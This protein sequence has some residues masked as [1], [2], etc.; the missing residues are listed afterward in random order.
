MGC[1][2]E[3]EGDFFFTCADPIS[4]E[5]DLHVHCGRHWEWWLWSC[6]CVEFPLTCTNLAVNWA[7]KV[8]RTVALIT[9]GFFLLLWPSTTFS[10]KIFAASRTSCVWITSSPY[11]SAS[12]NWWISNTPVVLVPEDQISVGVLSTTL[13]YPCIVRASICCNFTGVVVFFLQ[14]AAQNFKL[15]EFAVTRLYCAWSRYTMTRASGRSI[16]NYS[17]NCLQWGEETNQWSQCLSQLVRLHVARVSIYGPTHIMHCRTLLRSSTAWI[18]LANF[19]LKPNTMA[20]SG[21]FITSHLFLLMLQTNTT[22]AS[23]KLTYISIGSRWLL[24]YYNVAI[25]YYRSVTGFPS[26]SGQLAGNHYQQ[27]YY[28]LCTLNFT[29]MSSYSHYYTARVLNN[30]WNHAS[31]ALTNFPHYSG[32]PAKLGCQIL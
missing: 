13:W 10:A 5:Y 30:N 11:N 29:I 25:Y 7:A 24:Y 21:G 9:V 1:N 32:I 4:F 17:L 31:T 20:P 15:W 16:V 22:C 6:A 3:I 19:T 26:Y 23:V 27:K 28:Q 14:L 2:T 8:K 12:S 18:L